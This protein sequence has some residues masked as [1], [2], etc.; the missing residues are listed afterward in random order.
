MKILS[1]M[2]LAVL[3]LPISPFLII[4]FG[5]AELYKLY[6]EVLKNVEKYL[7]EIESDKN[8]QENTGD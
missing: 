5:G 6:E 4:F 8:V 3:L 1:A 7:D 2:C